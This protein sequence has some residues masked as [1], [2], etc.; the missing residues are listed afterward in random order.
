M[1]TKIACNPFSGRIFRGRVNEELKVWVGKKQDVTSDVLE[2]VIAKAEF[3][4]G[5]FEI[6]GG[7]RKWVI[8]VTELPKVEGGA[9]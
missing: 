2:S 3:H 4:K 1:T 9:T 6:E 8:T 5:S 7:G